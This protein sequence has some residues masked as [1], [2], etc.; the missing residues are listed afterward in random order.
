MLPA[1]RR[2]LASAG[3]AVVAVLVADDESLPD[4]VLFP[5]QLTKAVSA[6]STAAKA[7]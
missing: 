7:S 2:V 4:L 1:P 3:A 5:P 6:S